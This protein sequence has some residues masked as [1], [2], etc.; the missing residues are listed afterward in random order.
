[1]KKFRYRAELPPD[2]G[3]SWQAPHDVTLN[4]GPSPSAR[5]NRRFITACPRA[6]VSSCAAVRD[7]IGSPRFP[8]TPG[9]IG[10]SPL[11]RNGKKKQP[12]KK[13]AEPPR[14]MTPIDRRM[15]TARPPNQTVAWALSRGEEVGSE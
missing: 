13:H 14:T 15:D 3:R 1:M 8:V 4:A 12:A 9:A 11:G 6:N 10:P 2:A 7:G 5:L